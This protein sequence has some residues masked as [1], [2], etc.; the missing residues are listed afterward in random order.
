MTVQHHSS[1]LKMLKEGAEA[2]YKAKSFLALNWTDQMPVEKKKNAV[3][4]NMQT[5]CRA[6]SYRKKSKWQ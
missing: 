4:K 3:A 6:N 5:L 2:S 1:F